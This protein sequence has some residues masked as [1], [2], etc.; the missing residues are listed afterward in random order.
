MPEIII[1]KV[2]HR[3]LY[4]NI[5]T[6]VKTLLI[7]CCFCRNVYKPTHD[8][9]MEAFATNDMDSREQWLTGCCGAPC[10]DKHVPNI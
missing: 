6:E 4:G 1:N 9:K 2:L 5:H 10:W 8:T 3:P 7:R